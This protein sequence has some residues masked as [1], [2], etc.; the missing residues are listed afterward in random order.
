MTQF[1]RVEVTEFGEVIGYPWGGGP[2]VVLRRMMGLT[3]EPLCSEAAH[4]QMLAWWKA[5]R[6]WDVPLAL[7]PILLGVIRATF[8]PSVP[9]STATLRAVES[10][11]GALLVVAAAIAG[12]ET[13]PPP[14]FPPPMP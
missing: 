1:A 4:A 10:L 7:E 2:P 6:G 3:T 14:P 11:L 9:A 13:P 8:V 5:N 12:L